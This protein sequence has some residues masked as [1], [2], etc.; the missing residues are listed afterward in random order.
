MP[1]IRTLAVIEINGIG[2]SNSECEKLKCIL[3]EKLT[4]IETEAYS[5]AKRSFSLTSPDDVSRVLFLELCLPP[6]GDPNAPPV[7]AASRRATG[8]GRNQ[9]LKQL[10]T[11]KAVLEKL[12]KF[13]RLPK[14][15][16]E[17]R[18]I[19]SALTKVVFPY[20]RK[21]CE[22]KSLGMFRIFSESQ[23]HT[24]TGRVSFKEP[25]LQNVPNEFDIKVPLT[26]TYMETDSNNTPVACKQSVS[27]KIQSLTSPGEVFAVSM[28]SCFTATEGFVLL[29]ADYSQLELRLIAH[30]SKDEKL[31][32]HLNGKG[33]V[34]KSIA[35]DVNSIDVDSV[36][37]QQRQR[38]KQICYG[39]IYGI[40]PKALGEQLEVSE[41]DASMFI[42]QFKSKYLGV[43]TYIK[44]TIAQAK[45]DGYVRTL[46]GRKRFL[47]ALVSSNTHART[48][49]ERQAVNTTV[50]GSAADLVK[51]AMNSIDRKI[52]EKY[53]RCVLDIRYNKG[54]DR[55]K[56]PAKKTEV[57]TNTDKSNYFGAFLVLQLHDE[58]IYEVNRRNLEEMKELVKSEMEIAMKLSVRMPVKL[59]VGEK[60]GKMIDC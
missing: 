41:D 10:S 24:S 52:Q 28:R 20:E 50:Q 9:K 46:M 13:H 25:N 7:P 30:L 3:K 26:S 1:T 36:N 58:L 57:G 32:K 11:S 17:W 31:L 6:N 27:T 15:I 22:C 54:C 12:V 38:A 40:G 45:Q 53:G 39:I 51:K 34:F 23:Y 19:N 44:N 2:F 37:A 8:K 35:A 5:L 47:P 60:W 21:K 29:A 18:R 4:T 42:E 33:D 55:T 48:Q 16:L 49:A 56:P 43:K 59:K 14:L